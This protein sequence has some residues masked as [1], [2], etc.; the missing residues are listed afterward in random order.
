MDKP[1]TCTE[2]KF[3]IDLMQTQQIPKTS[4]SSEYF[5]KK[6]SLYAVGIIYEFKRTKKLYI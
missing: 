3:P 1:C 2:I 4:T 6:L 5:S